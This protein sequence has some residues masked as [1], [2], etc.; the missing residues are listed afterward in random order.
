MTSAG[1]R[2]AFRLEVTRPHG[3]RPTLHVIDAPFALFG[4]AQGCGLRLDHPA[5]SHRHTYLQAV[6]GRIYSI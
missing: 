3:G 4:R 6:F 5:V 1:W 2:G